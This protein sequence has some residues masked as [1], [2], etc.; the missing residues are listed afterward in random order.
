MEP[1]ELFFYSL[2]L[3]ALLNPLKPKTPRSGASLKTVLLNTRAQGHAE[4]MERFSSNAVSRINRLIILIAVLLF[5]SGP[6][7]AGLLNNGS[8][9]DAG[10]TP[11]GTWTEHYWGGGPGQAGN[12]IEAFKKGAGQFAEA[13]YWSLIDASLAKVEQLS[14]NVY[15]T[16]YTGGMLSLSNQG[17]W[18]NGTTSG[19]DYVEI[20]MTSFTN[21]TTLYPDGR[22]AF[23]I[24]GYGIYDN[25]TGD[26]Q[27]VWITA[28]YGP[29][30]PRVDTL[31][32]AWNPVKRIEGDWVYQSGE[33]AGSTISINAVP[34]PPAVWLLGSGLLGLVAIRRRMQK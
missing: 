24:T 21:M 16:T 27:K 20:G 31:Y 32:S 8:W 7:E 30:V 15:K 23:S 14:P 2:P 6:S 3:A 19:Y 9:S 22:M 12:R 18:W 29:G 1:M 5:S 28:T 11:I 10:G 34:I 33:L 13:A 17:P 26:D 25:P 4:P